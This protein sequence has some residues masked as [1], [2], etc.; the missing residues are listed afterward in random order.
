MCTVSVVQTPTDPPRTRHRDGLLLRVMCNRDEQRSREASVGPVVK[1]CGTR[2]AI[3]PLDPPSGGT[4]IGAN[5]AGLIACVLN[6][7]PAAQVAGGKTPSDF[8]SRGEIVPRVLACTDLEEAMLAA[9]NLDPREFPPFRLLI[10]NAQSRVVIRTDGRVA[11]HEEAF[12]APAHMMLASSGLG[13]AFVEPVRGELFAHMFETHPDAMMAQERF[14]EHSWPDRPEL[15]VLMSRADARTV[16]R[17]SVELYVDTVSVR[18]ARLDESLC[19]EI[20]TCVSLN[21]THMRAAA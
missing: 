10:Q 13:D 20:E 16:S 1:R 6:A 3:M 19:A 11:K 5:D 7:N 2:L 18:H 17:T 21:L 4:W 15:S 9:G 14:H 12:A 8:R